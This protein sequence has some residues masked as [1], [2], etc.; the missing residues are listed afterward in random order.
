MQSSIETLLQ[1]LIHA[2]LMINCSF[3]KA[4]GQEKGAEGSQLELA[5]PS[6]GDEQKHRRQTQHHT[7][8]HTRRK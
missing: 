5:V 7:H 3:D 4:K 1:H 6:T 2:S 8:T